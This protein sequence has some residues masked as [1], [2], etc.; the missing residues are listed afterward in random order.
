MGCTLPAPH[1]LCTQAAALPV[2][3]QRGCA[4][5]SSTNRLSPGSQHN[6][7]CGA[8][9]AD[10]AHL[11]RAAVGRRGARQG[12]EGGGLGEAGRQATA[13]E[14]AQHTG[15]VWRHASALAASCAA[16][17]LP[18]YHARL[19]RPMSKMP[20][21]QPFNTHALLISLTTSPCHGSPAQVHAEDAGHHGAQRRCKR[22]NGQQQL[23]AV[24][25]RGTVGWCRGSGGW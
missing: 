24:D 12:R 3:P 20:A 10:D 21:T 6:H 23:Q 17:T 19:R 16:A 2:Q 5:C 18:V 4:L 15:C 8:P 25:L 14:P 1:P 22:G 11:Q 9:E 13:A 7:G